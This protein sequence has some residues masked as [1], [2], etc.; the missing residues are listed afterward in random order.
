ME[1][2][3][4][5]ALITGGGT[6]IGRAV[7]LALAQAGAAGVAVHYSRSESEANE[8]VRLL[9]E[10]GVRAAALQGDVAVKEEAERVVAAAAEALGGLSVLVQS[11]GTTRVIPFRDLDAVTDDVWDRLLSVNLRGAFQVC[12][13]AAPALRASGDAG[14]VNVGSIAGIRAGGSSIPYGVSKAGLHQL[15]R[16][17]AVALAPE[18]TVNAVAPGLVSTRWFRDVDQG[19]AAKLESD[20][21]ATT[22]RRRVAT[23]E[24]VADLVVGLLRSSMVTGETVVVDGGRSLVY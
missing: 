14:I 21:A 5:R 10:A 22:P 4:S 24:D 11:A 1:L 20:T 9:Q 19:L 23:A 8:T 15:T 3:G 17:L 18:I 2:K 7:A 16:S 6:G 12:R 13:A